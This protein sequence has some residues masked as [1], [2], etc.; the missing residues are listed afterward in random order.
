MKVEP[1]LIT[2]LVAAALTLAIAFGAPVD[3]AQRQAILQ[4]AS[5]VVAILVAS[6]IILRNATYTA[7]DVETI[8]AESYELG[9]MAA[10]AD[11]A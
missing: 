10:S 11:V 4:F 7:R 8:K 9:A 3:D 5:A 6:G 2:Q 1:V